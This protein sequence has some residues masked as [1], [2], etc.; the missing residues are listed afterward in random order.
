MRD[1]LYI[2]IIDDLPMGISEHSHPLWEIVYYTYGTG[3]L[4]IGSEEIPFEP[5]KI[6]CQ[7]PGIIHSEVSTDGFRNIHFFIQTFTPIGK[8]IPQFFD[9]ES[10]DFQ[11][12]LM[13]IYRVYH[14]K[15][16]NWRNTI[17]CLVSA[18][19]QYML[20]WH[21]EKRISPLVEKF[22]N[23]LISNIPNKNFCV[24]K[25][26]NEIP[27]SHD[28]FRSLFKA[29]TGKTPHQYIMEKRINSAKMLLENRGVNTLSV[30]EIADLLGFEDPLYFS[31]VFRRATGKCPREWGI[32][33]DRGQRTEDS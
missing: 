10:C 31:R 8:G 1:L 9:N 21:S 28:Y 6:V 22:E 4:K 2:N 24:D 30:S 12:I 23:I 16:S 27:L 29:E 14:K 5:K 11:N 18:L 32:A 13:Q 25:A 33:V 7:P 19:H 3:I 26:L 20:S 17:E 15:Q